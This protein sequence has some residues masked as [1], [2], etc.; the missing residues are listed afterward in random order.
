MTA[1]SEIECHDKTYLY[2]TL[3]RNRMAD[4]NTAEWYVVWGTASVRVKMCRGWRTGPGLSSWNIVE[5]LSKSE[6][7]IKTYSHYNYGE[8][9]I[10][11]YS[12]TFTKV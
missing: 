4:M 8:S 6:A 7:K 2:M 12:G 1:E 11:E 9:L 3:F 5:R 10:M